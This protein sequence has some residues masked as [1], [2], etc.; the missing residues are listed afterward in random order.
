MASPA[1][2]YTS[3]LP[4][5]AASV[6]ATIKSLG[7]S[8]FFH[9]GLQSGSRNTDDDEADE[10]VSLAKSF[11]SPRSL[12]PSPEASI[13]SASAGEA[14]ARSTS[15][16]PAGWLGA[17]TS[18]DEVITTAGPGAASFAYA[19]RDASPSH[20]YSYLGLSRNNNERSQ[21]QAPNSLFSSGN[22]CDESP[23]VDAPSARGGVPLLKVNVNAAASHHLRA[24]PSASS[25]S[26]SNKPSPHTAATHF[27]SSTSTR[28][29]SSGPN[30]A[31]PVNS[32]A[33]PDFW[34]GIASATAAATLPPAGPRTH[35]LTRSQSTGSYQPA[36]A[37]TTSGKVRKKGSSSA[38]ETLEA[39]QFAPHVSSA[40]KTEYEPKEIDSMDITSGAGLLPN[41]KQLSP[42][43]ESPFSDEYRASP[44][45]G[46]TASINSSAF[47]S[48]P[49]DMPICYI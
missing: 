26:S 13:T 31:M 43:N 48:F 28:Y 27:S 2:S 17:S 49:S 8:P 42:I 15:A 45:Q 19:N 10:Q 35:Y 3:S 21:Q 7:R 1:P 40:L 34:N 32:T 46:D 20:S 24:Q 11:R 23:G 6:S 14:K 29:P 38:V 9:A 16:S 36:V 12:S 4:H 37:A 39:H 22:G 44:I 30:S 18:N 33:D 5:S 25:F 47:S 41:H